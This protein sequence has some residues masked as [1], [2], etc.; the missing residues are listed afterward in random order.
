[1]PAGTDVMRICVNT[2]LHPIPTPSLFQRGTKMLT[3]LKTLVLAII[4][5]ALTAHATAQEMLA[6]V[7]QKDT[8]EGTRFF[9]VFHNGQFNSQELAKTAQRACDAIQKLGTCEAHF[10]DVRGGV[11]MT[12]ISDVQSGLQPLLLGF[13]SH[14]GKLAWVG[15][16]ITRN[17][18]DKTDW[19][20]STNHRGEHRGDWQNIEFRNFAR[21]N[22]SFQFAD[23]DAGARKLQFQ[24]Q[25]GF[26]DGRGVDVSTPR[27]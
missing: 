2:R 14:D 6:K 12:K 26:G 4:V 5:C 22:V 7:R 18:G 8:Y 21:R 23:D 3:T 15:Y 16:R 24:L 1:M 27:P 25:Y 10:H 13:I 11:E 19:I 20:S 17:G 9:A